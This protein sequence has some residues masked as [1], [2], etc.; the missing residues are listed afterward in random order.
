MFARF[1]LILFRVL[2]ER[3]DRDLSVVP[4]P[5][6]KMLG[7]KKPEFLEQRMFELQEYMRSVRPACV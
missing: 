7:N 4:F 5:K 2:R 6:K 1:A 3:Y